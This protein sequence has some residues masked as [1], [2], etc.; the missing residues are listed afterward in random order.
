MEVLYCV[1]FYQLEG[2]P[3]TIL[4]GNRAID[5]HSMNST[6][7]G[8][9]G[10]MIDKFRQKR[11]QEFFEVQRLCKENSVVLTEKL[12]QKGTLDLSPLP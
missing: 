11:L 6:L 10:A 9:Q 2:T 3:A 7:Q 4:T 8:E 1:M 5:D 12:L